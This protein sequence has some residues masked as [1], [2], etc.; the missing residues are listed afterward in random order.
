MK[1]ALASVVIISAVLTVQAS[2]VKS[3]IAH[4]GASGYAPEHTRAAYLLA[5]KQHAD[6][7]EQDLGI[8][9]DGQL[10]C[11]HDAS[12]ERTTDVAK[13]FPSRFVEFPGANGPVKHW[14]LYDF[15][16]AEVKRLDAGSWF[17]PKYTGERIL[18]WQETIDLVKGKAGLF[19]E[20]KSPEIY[21]ARGV[22]MEPIVVDS[23]RKNGLTAPGATRLIFQSFDELSLRALA[24]DLPS[25]PR[26]F[27]MEGPLAQI[28][29]TP[30]KIKEAS[31][32]VS[33][34]GPAKAIVE[35]HPEIVRWAHA[36]SLTVT[37][38]TFRESDRGQY[39]SVRD[40]MHHFLFD[41]GVDAVFTDN[42]DKF[43]RQ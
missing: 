30:D 31:T 41:L 26:V 39:S 25:I 8:T 3:A 23:I 33:G 20:L 5:I 7:V 42:P 32:F 10:V 37:P 15:T 16:L 36:S 2:S 18:T 12:L 11:L 19:P 4:R 1:H 14:M 13:V 17:D 21:R 22:E 28:W 43:P 29:L 27:L 24:R 40:E 9:K 34:L 35:A 6:F 38:Y